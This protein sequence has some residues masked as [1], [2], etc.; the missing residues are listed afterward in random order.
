MFCQ[1][2]EPLLK[3]FLSSF[4]L[5]PTSTWLTAMASSKVYQRTGFKAIV[6][7]KVEAQAAQK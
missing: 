1:A 5:P 2:F 4:S 7:E 6:V 3:R